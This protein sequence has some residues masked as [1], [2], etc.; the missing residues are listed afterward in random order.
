MLLDKIIGHSKVINHLKK[1]VENE[2]VSHAQMF[3]GPEGAGVLETAIAYAELVLNSKKPEELNKDNS[4]LFTHP[5]LHFVYPV[6]TNTEVKSKPKSKDF[7]QDWN[8]F[9]SESEYPNIVDW[10]EKIGIEKKA[11]IISVNEAEEIVR[12]MSLKSYEGDYKVMIIWM[13]EMMNIATSNKLLKIIEEPFGK[14]LFIFVTENENQIISTIKSRT[15]KVYFNRLS[16][17]EVK[18]YLINRHYIDEEKAADIATRSDGNIRNA[19][20]LMKDGHLENQYQEIFVDW[21]RASFKA[22]TGMLVKWA[23]EMAKM[24]KQ[25]QLNFLRYSSRVFRQALLEN[26]EAKDL[27]FLKV[28]AGGFKFES[29][30]TFV[31]GQNIHI[32]L[33]EIDEG[34]FHIE[35]NG[36]PKIV[37]LDLSLK[38]TRGLHVKYK[39]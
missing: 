31:H 15:Q 20:D 19:I 7:S 35:R 37:L 12:L 27:S 34:I 24:G 21:V 25:F 23:E 4:K 30:I 8:E 1:T 6:N 33:H 10:Y 13:P 2:M 36:N 22:D 18:T 29:F 38:I 3:V 28:E 14:T 17:E 39:E 11:G 5:D 9:L 32:I 16:D 26:Y